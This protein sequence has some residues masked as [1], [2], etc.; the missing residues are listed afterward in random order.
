MS[1]QT[2]YPKLIEQLDKLNRCEHCP[3]Y[4]GETVHRDEE[5]EQVINSLECM[6]L[7]GD[8][9]YCPWH[10]RNCPCYTTAIHFHRERLKNELDMHIKIRQGD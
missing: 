10:E 7:Y 5:Q 4:Y 1:D 8:K 2:K 6:E 3:T 9:L